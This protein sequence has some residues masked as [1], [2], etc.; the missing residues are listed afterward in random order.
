MARQ[1]SLIK[2]EG[3]L[4]DLTFYKG[5]N[6]YLVRRKGGVDKQRINTD[7][8]FTRTR[9]N[10]NEFSGIAKSG[11]ILRRTL[12]PML[13]KAK[14]NSAVSRLVSILSRVKNEDLV[15]ERGKRN[16][17]QGLTTTEGKNALKGFNFN[18]EAPLETVLLTDYQLNTTTGEVTIPNVNP[19][20][21]VATP[22]GATHISFTTA[23]AHVDFTT[24]EKRLEVSPTT[25]IPIDN[26]TTEIVLSPV[27]GPIEDENL[28]FV[29]QIEYFQEINGVQYSLNNGSYNVLSIL[30]VL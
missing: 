10:G 26:T 17:A 21:N 5:E 13:K 15:S 23:I 12:N 8:A 1:K 9:E 6:G 27:V 19:T 14:D 30:E 28:L 29:I 3:T 24:E 16:V 2:I 25:T 22:Q 7:P 20:Q 18:K 4:D 11:K